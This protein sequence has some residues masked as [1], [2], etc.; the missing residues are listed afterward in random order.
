MM[1]ESKRTESQ[2]HSEDNCTAATNDYR[3]DHC[4]DRAA[5]VG[6]VGVGE[7]NTIE[8]DFPDACDKSA[9][10]RDDKERVSR[11]AGEADDAEGRFERLLLAANNHQAEMKDPGGNKRPEGDKQWNKNNKDNRTDPAPHHL[12]HRA[13][14]AAHNLA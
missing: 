4:Q 3:K 7:P 9:T 1:R 8:D 10:N 2:H 14:L 11:A 5:S 12:Y 6:L 13:F